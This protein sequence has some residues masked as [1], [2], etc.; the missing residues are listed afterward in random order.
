MTLLIS[1]ILIYFTLSAVAD[2]A[3]IHKKSDLWHSLRAALDVAMVAYV[4][5][6]LSQQPIIPANWE[7]YFFLGIF[8]LTMRDIS[9][10]IILGIGTTSWIDRNINGWWRLCIWAV[11]GFLSLIYFIW[12]FSNSLII[13]CL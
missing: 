1:F 11:G 12:Y 13:K 5:F 9:R 7:S 10:T 3:M 6:I 8:A 4:I 2:W